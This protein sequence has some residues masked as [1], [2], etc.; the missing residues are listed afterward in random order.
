M[1]NHVQQEDIKRFATTFDSSALRGSRIMVTG[2]T[3]LLGS[4]MVRC[5]LALNEHQQAH[6]SII[7]VV[8][9]LDKAIQ[10]LGAP[11][12]QHQYY[13][14]DFASSQ[15]FIPEEAPTHIIHFAAPTASRYFVE[16]PAETF[17]IV[18]DG[19]RTIL[20][21]ART[22][23][24]KSVVYASSLEVYGTILDDTTALTEDRQ[25]YLDP[26][27][28]RSSYPMAKRAAECLCHAYATEY[29]LPVKTAR[30]A[31]TFGAGVAADDNRVFAQFARSIIDGRD[32]EL[33][34]TG[35]LSRCYC[36]TMDAMSAMLCLAT[37]G[38]SGLAY[39]IANEDT[40]ISIAD[41][42]HM[43]C[44]EFNPALQVV[45][46][47][48]EGMG[49]SPTTRLRL[50]TRRMRNLGWKPAYGLHEMFARLIESIK[51]DRP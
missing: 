30:L 46:R 34:T 36:Y 47:P 37:R 7:S 32:I 44:H 50:D 1:M 42:A 22:H 10:L 39:N 26:M 6:I 41:M 5:L 11:T 15:S 4:C 49:Y 18:L 38:D 45:I 28:T 35:L 3:G 31:Q 8:R 2:A 21:Y 51:Q 25:G 16:H 17:A 23:A 48:T 24:V 27:D 20:E 14:Y 9:N 13:V 12:P 19:T 29:G 33:H 43:L 40:Y